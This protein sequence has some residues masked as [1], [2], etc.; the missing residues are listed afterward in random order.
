MGG[1]L[2]VQLVEAASLTTKGLVREGCGSL[3]SVDAGVPSRNH[4][5]TGTVHVT[6]RFASILSPV[7]LCE[8]ALSAST[9]LLELT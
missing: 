3:R 2:A 4:I 9:A 6:A 1:I 5:E 7:M 8:R